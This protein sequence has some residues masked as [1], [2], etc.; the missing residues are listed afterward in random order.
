MSDVL[1]LMFI[2]L[3]SWLVLYLIFTGLGL[4]I[5]R[6]FK[7]KMGQEEDLLTSFWLGWAFSILALQLWHLLYPVNSWIF[8]FI[9]INYRY[10]N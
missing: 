6:L 7:K 8:I 1:K 3:Y 9:S 5:S 2:V 4:F 10:Y